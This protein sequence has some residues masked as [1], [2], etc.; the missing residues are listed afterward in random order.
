MPGDVETAPA[1]VERE[2]VFV[3]AE[4]AAEPEPAAKAEPK[5]KRTRAPVES[6]PAPAVEDP[7]RPRRSGWW[8]K[9]RGG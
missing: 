7:A 4:P 3:A 2:P 1:P 8:N 6:T 9:M 5:P